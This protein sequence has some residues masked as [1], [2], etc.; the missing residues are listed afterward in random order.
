MQE[1]LYDVISEMK[2]PKV[3]FHLARRCFLL[4]VL[5]KQAAL[6]E[7]YALEGTEGGHQGIQV[8]SP[9]AHKELN[10]AKTFL[11]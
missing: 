4:L 11:A 3:N 7:G 6:L 8:L 10:A 9:T 5:M 2:L 1:S